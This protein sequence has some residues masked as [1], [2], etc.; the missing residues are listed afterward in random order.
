ML[1]DLEAF[2]VSCLTPD[3]LMRYVTTIF[4]FPAGLLWIL[5]CHISSRLGRCSSS[6]WTWTRTTNLAGSFL[7]A[8]FCA[9]SALALQ[10]FMCYAHPNG[11]RS[12]LKYPGIF[13]GTEK[14]F[15]MISF[16]ISILGVIALI[17]LAVCG[18]G[19]WSVPR[20][21]AIRSDRVGAFAFL[22]SKFRMDTWWYGLPV[23]FR[24]PLLSLCPVVATDFPPNQAA[25]LATV[26]LAFLLMHVRFSPWKVPLMNVADGCIQ[27]LV[28]LL[29]I[30]TPTY[31]ESLEQMKDFRQRVAFGVLAS[32]AVAV[33]SLAFPL[34]VVFCYIIAKQRRCPCRGGLDSN[35][36]FRVLNLGTR[37]TSMKMTQR[38]KQVAAAMLKAEGTSIYRGL[39]ALHPSDAARIDAVINMVAT[40]I[41]RLPETWG[42]Q[43]FSED[44]LDGVSRGHAQ[45]NKC[46]AAFEL[47]S[48]RA[49]QPNVDEASTMG[50]Q[51]NVS[52]D[53]DASESLASLPNQPHQ[54]V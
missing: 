44:D 46:V 21:A 51:G 35:E 50:G 32:I 12:L 29:V 6:Q 52:V 33:V 18:W 39:D 11:L 3:P 23:L 48:P 17:F 15:A 8:G 36:H 47:P 1:L 38:M 4:L 2:S 53:S 14:H 16:G 7:Q 28:L 25:L 37:E 30:I 45:L 41:L 19:I 42:S 34:L 13:C 10:P 5:V 26:L 27:T 24:G 22:I 43:D 40:E 20:W 54:D 49:M 9:M 31:T